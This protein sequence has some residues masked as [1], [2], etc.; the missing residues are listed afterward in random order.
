MLNDVL[1]VLKQAIQL[2]ED[3]Q[4]YY[5]EAAAR[6]RNPLAQTTFEKLVGWEE[7]H[8]QY[9]TA[10]YDAMQ[11]QR[12]WPPMSQ[13]GV[14]AVDIKQEAVSIFQ[15][16]LAQID[17]MVPEETGLTEL[18]QGAMEME[19][20]SIAL[21]HTGAEQAADEN[22]REFYEFLVAQEQGH[23]DLLATTLEYLDDPDSW[24]FTQ[25]QW[26]VEG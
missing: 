11:Q 22:T 26:T 21:Y 9:L 7:E 13:M 25:E 20:Q 3:G 19:R 18:Y 1:E 24:Y 5:S 10:Y 17:E 4:K 16:A 14:R 15:Q 8:K 6:V 23:L 12:E 2:E